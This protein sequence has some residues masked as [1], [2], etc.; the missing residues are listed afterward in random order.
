MFIFLLFIAG[1]VRLDAIGPKT[2]FLGDQG[3][4]ATELYQSFQQGHLPVAGPVH[5]NGIRSGPVMYYLFAPSFF[6]SGFNPIAIAVFMAFLGV[7]TVSLLFLLG[8]KLYGT[9]PAF[10][11]AGLYAVSPLIAAQSRAIWPPALL[12]FFS[13]VALLGIVLMDKKRNPAWLLLVSASCAVMSQMYIPSLPTVGFFGLS[14]LFVLFRLRKNHSVKILLFWLLMSAGCFL[15]IW[16]PYLHY[17][18]AHEFEDIRTFILTTL[19][20][21]APSSALAS[22]MSDRVSLVRSVFEKVLPGAGGI[23][24]VVALIAG[25]FRAKL[26]VAWFLIAG[27]PIILFRGP[28]FEHY[29]SMLI[30]LPFLLLGILLQRIIAYSKYLI[31]P[32]VLLLLFLQL[33]AGPK[34]PVYN[35]LARTQGVVDEMIAQAKGREFSFTLL[36][37]RSFSDYHYR[38]FFMQ[39]NIVP[40]I[41]YE[42][43]YPILFLLCEQQPCPSWEG[44]QKRGI[45]AV[46]CYEQRCAPWYPDKRLTGWV[47]EREVD[48]EGAHLLTLRMNAVQ[49]P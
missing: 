20:S 39:K 13:V 23:F 36:S 31:L 35:D 12:P 9:V 27:L 45:I 38:Y 1:L 46:L 3:V 30:P 7:I 44:L 4:I 34:V 17:E 29:A 40:S 14:G 15:A 19:F 5:S 37:S 6:L 41:I 28:T 18:A 25:A 24:M 10:L 22:T 16:F 33:S 21:S 42:D 48:I 11:V 49:L 43:D 8:E 47:F 2:E 26:L 32:I